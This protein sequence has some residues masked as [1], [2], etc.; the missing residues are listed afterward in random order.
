MYD[1]TSFDSSW[2]LYLWIYCKDHNI[3]IIREPIRLEFEF[4]G[5]KYGYHPDFLIDG[6][7]VELKG[8]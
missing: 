7:L 2:E 4:N 6:Q 5:K 8:N 3:K 1:N